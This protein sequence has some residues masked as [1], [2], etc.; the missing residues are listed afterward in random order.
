MTKTIP[1]ELEF[2]DNGSVTI[3][4]KTG[5]HY[6]SGEDYNYVHHVDPDMRPNSNNS[7]N[8]RLGIGNDVMSL[9]SDMRFEYAHGVLQT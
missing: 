5:K 6:A 8:L 4:I 3:T 1:M 7:Y 2:D 9:V